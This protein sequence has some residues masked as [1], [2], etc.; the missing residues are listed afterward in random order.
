MIIAFFFFPFWDSVPKAGQKI[1]ITDLPPAKNA[2]CSKNAYI[3]MEG[4]VE[5]VKEDG[6]FVLRGETNILIVGTKYKYEIC[7]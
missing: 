7:S 4:F 1:K 6:S 5:D 2:P 3:R